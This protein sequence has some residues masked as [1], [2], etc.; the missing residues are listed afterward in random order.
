M[1]AASSRMVSH[2][3]ISL[4]RNAIPRRRAACTTDSATMLSR[5][6]CKKPAVTS[7]FEVSMTSANAS[8][9]T[10]S[11]GVCGGVAGPSVTLIAA[12]AFSSILP[13]GVSGNSSRTTIWC[14]TR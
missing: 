5:P 1:A 10:S 7:T 4:A 14:G 2:S 12:K 3:T 9:S 8:A 11:V 13:C 6:I